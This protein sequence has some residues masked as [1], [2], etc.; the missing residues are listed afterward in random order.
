MAGTLQVHVDRLNTKK[1][2]FEREIIAKTAKIRQDHSYPP[3]DGSAELE[4]I[5]EEIGDAEKKIRDINQKIADLQIT[6]PNQL[7]VLNWVDPQI[8]TSGLVPIEFGSIQYKVLKVVALKI[9]SRPTE[10]NVSLCTFQ[11][12]ACRNLPQLY[13]VHK[14]RI[15]SEEKSVN[16]AAFRVFDT[17]IF[18]HLVTNPGSAQ[19]SPDRFNSLKTRQRHQGNKTPQPTR[20]KSSEFA[21][22]QE[23]DFHKLYYVEA[24]NTFFPV[25]VSQELSRLHHKFIK[26][27]ESDHRLPEQLHRIDQAGGVFT[28]KIFR[29][30]H[31][32]IV[33]IHWMSPLGEEK[34]LS[35][36]PLALWSYRS[37]ISILQHEL[38]QHFRRFCIDPDQKDKDANYFFE[39]KYINR[40]PGSAFEWDDWFVDLSTMTARY[41][42]SHA[43]MFPDVELKREEVIWYYAHKSVLNGSPCWVATS[44][45]EAKRL[46]TLY[47]KAERVFLVTGEE[48]DPSPS[49]LTMQWTSGNLR[50]IMAT[51]SFFKVSRARRSILLENNLN[52]IKIEFFRHYWPGSTIRGDAMLQCSQWFS[53][54]KSHFN[55]IDNARSYC[56]LEPPPVENVSDALESLFFIHVALHVHG[57]DCNGTC[58]ALQNR[59]N[60][61]GILFSKLSPLLTVVL[62][63]SMRDV[64]QIVSSAFDPAIFKF[65]KTTWDCKVCFHEDREGSGFRWPVVVLN[66]EKW[67]KSWEHPPISHDPLTDC[68]HGLLCQWAFEVSKLHRDPDKFLRPRSMAW[69]LCELPSVPFPDGY[70]ELYKLFIAIAGI[71]MKHKIGDVC[72]ANVMNVFAQ[73]S[74]FEDPSRHWQISSSESDFVRNSR[75]KKCHVRIEG[76]DE[77]KC[78][79]FK[80]YIA[81]VNAYVNHLAQKVFDLPAHRSLLPPLLLEK[82]YAVMNTSGDIRINLP[83]G[84]RKLSPRLRLIYIVDQAHQDYNHAL[85]AGL[86]QIPFVVTPHTDV[87]TEVLRTAD[88]L[89]ETLKQFRQ[90]RRILEAQLPEIL[91]KEGARDDVLLHVPGG[92]I[93]DDA[94]DQSSR[95]SS[96]I[97]KFLN[98]LKVV[99]EQIAELLLID[100]LL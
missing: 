88:S 92:A 44:L 98:G 39:D 93:D 67:V 73:C 33:C 99:I 83:S 75:N 1:D 30:N 49:I 96:R 71:S 87:V 23:S 95:H 86:V 21:V 78:K 54:L 11:H 9:A 16:D 36:S 77:M 97:I 84:L 85:H 41:K 56:D 64:K 8:A 45:D 100:S 58:D 53:S 57:D 51:D 63:K 82:V 18:P 37:L 25:L 81:R 5:L 65:G 89:K 2:F 59:E 10:D 47:L 79:E 70:H 50:D 34:V 66:G 68:S 12:P 40:D 52:G 24:N 26:D 28:F 6:Q 32:S 90:I 91:Q 42:S 19:S 14:K 13:D 62:R 38:E 20:G 74:Y 31:T 43:L 69:K 48:Y 46:E 4:C 94:I 29:W 22:R 27:L 61:L 76:L 17:T 3:G 60:Y 72:V 15:D 80:D 35:H 7:P 55:D